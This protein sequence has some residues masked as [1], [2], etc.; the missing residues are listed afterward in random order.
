MQSLRYV[1]PPEALLTQLELYAE[2]RQEDLDEIR[3]RANREPGCALPGRP[4]FPD[5]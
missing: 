5:F 1:E 3:E 4:A 2:E